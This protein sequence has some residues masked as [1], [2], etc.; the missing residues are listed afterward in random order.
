MTD[1]SVA[2]P[3]VV[4]AIELAWREAE[5][6]DR[7]QYAAWQELYADD[8]LYVI[9]ID[10]DADEFED[11]LNMVFDDKRMR[12]M[13]VTR[14]TQGYA[15]AAVDAATTTRT[16]S[17]F[18]P[19]QVTDTQVKLRAAQILVAFKRGRHDL[20]AADLDYTVRLGAG[21]ADDRLV[22]KVIRLIDSADA[23]PA[24]GFLL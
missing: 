24:T 23:V 17:R 2:D 9:P 5:L 14:M 7:K 10:R 6:L 18:V 11:V 8:A 3:R 19:A 16:V 4:R 13:R 21:A 20:W 22:R 12:A 1:I 15:I